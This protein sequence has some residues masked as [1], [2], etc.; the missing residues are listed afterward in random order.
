MNIFESCYRKIGFVLRRQFGLP[1][2]EESRLLPTEF[3]LCGRLDRTLHVYVRR[4]TDGH[5]LTEVN[6]L[7]GICKCI[8][9]DLNEVCEEVLS[10]VVVSFVDEQEKIIVSQDGENSTAFGTGGRNTYGD[11]VQPGWSDFPE[12]K[13]FLYTF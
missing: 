13:I 1:I 2:P 4:I 9:T 5:T 6:A 11:F 8:P 10:F 7:F 12:G 3:V